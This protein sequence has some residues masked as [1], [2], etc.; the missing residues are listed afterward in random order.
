MKISRTLKKVGKKA[1]KLGKEF[2]ST[3]LARAAR[4]K[5]TRGYI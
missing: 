5:K 4:G 3:P 1:R 2:S